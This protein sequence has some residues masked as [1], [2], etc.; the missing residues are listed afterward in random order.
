LGSAQNTTGLL[1]HA[2]GLGQLE[3]GGNSSKAPL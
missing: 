3:A 1:V 2:P